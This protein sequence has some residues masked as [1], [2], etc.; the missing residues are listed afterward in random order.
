MSRNAA[1]TGSMLLLLLASVL[2]APV[3][4][5]THRV[6]RVQGDLDLDGRLDEAIWRQ[7]VTI[8]L[9]F[10]VAPGENIPAP[11]R[12]VAYFAYNESHLLA[13][14]RAFDPN[15]DQIRANYKDHDD[16]WGDDWCSLVLDTFNDNRRQF[17]FF[18][19]PLGVQAEIVESSQ[20]GGG[21][22]D[23]IWDSGGRIDEE[24]YVVEFS[25]PFSSLRFPR[26]EGEQVWGIDVVRSYP[27]SVDH[28]LA[29]F[30]RLRDNNCYM[31][32][33]DSLIGFAGATPGR[34]IEITPTLSAIVTEA[35]TTP[36]STDES[37]EPGVT[38]R[39]GFTPNLT[40]SATVN[41]DFSQVE[42]DAAQLGINNQFALYYPESRPFFIEDA[43]FFST[44]MN[45][46]HTRSLA[47]PQWGAKVAG[48]EGSHAVGAF[49]GR[50]EITNLIF[51]YAEGSGLASLDRRSTGAVARYRRDVGSSS[52]LGMLLTDREGGGGYFNRLGGID[53]DVRLTP[54]DQISFQVV[55]SE[56]RYDE[57]TATDYGQPGGRFSGGAEE[58]LYYRDTRNLDLY[59]LYKRLDADFRADL[60]FIPQVGYYQ[61]EGGGEYAWL[62]DSDHW[63]NYLSINTGYELN[64]KLDGGPTLHRMFNTWLNYAGL[65]QSWVST[66]ITFG[67]RHYNGR[68]FDVRYYNLSSSISP[69]GRMT[70][71]MG[72]TLGETVDYAHSRPADRIRLQPSASFK[73]GRHFEATLGHIYEKLDV[74]DGRLYT[75]NVTEARLIY[76]LN[77]R[78]FVRVVLQR[79]DYNRNAAVYTATHDYDETSLL[80]Q[81]L[82]SYKMNPRTVLFLGYADNYYGADG[83]D[84]AQTDRT[85]FAKIG[86]AWTP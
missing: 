60:G 74:D 23:A 29:V 5:A 12:T 9:N 39:W 41:P 26:S 85:V 17:D 33:S 11:V 6:P 77:R 79:E 3:L 40:A 25:I 22:W 70:L 58:L 84:P 10:E 46:V 4:A 14:V 54:Q 49:V 35:Q 50:D 47:D 72:V 37:Y 56:T 62:N 27:R 61:I 34:N 42:A 8:E 53:G 68:E 71:G 18:V 13:A 65:M 57:Q 78:A 16:L 69:T 20:G 2:T 64:E 67:D 28:R 31:C 63:W 21:S 48:K 36:K 38:G 82:F 86:Y 73:L 80:S 15:P 81:L 19:N 83:A 45:T 55:R 44:R 24:G 1:F 59:F 51:P 7:A 43:E 76:Q 52:T 75:A 30:P 66:R 32:Q